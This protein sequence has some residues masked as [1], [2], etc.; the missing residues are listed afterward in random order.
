MNRHQ[1]RRA[2]GI[3]GEIRAAQIEEISQSAGCRIASP[4]GGGVEI[5]FRQTFVDRTLVVAGPQPH[6]DPGLAPRDFRGGNTGVLDGFPRNLE[7]QS[8]L[9]IEKRRLAGRNPEEFRIEVVDGW[10]KTS[11][12]GC[13]SVLRSISAIELRES[14]SGVVCCRLQTI[15]DYAPELFYSRGA[16]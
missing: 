12:D 8:L 2:G 14:A 4:T 7:Q 9:R 5:R 10:Q 1:R 15:P 11:A 3:H 16:R 13:N 6:E